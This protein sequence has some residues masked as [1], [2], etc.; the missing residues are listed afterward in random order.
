V[1]PEQYGLAV[2]TVQG[3]RFTHGDAAIPFCVQ[4]SSKPLTYCMATELHGEAT[5]HRHIGHEPNGRAFNATVLKKPEGIPHNPFINAG[6]IMAASLVKMEETEDARFDYVTS[7]WS[8]LTGGGKIGFQNSTYM[9]ERATASRNFC[10]GYMMA[11][12]GAFPAG[13]DLIKTLESYFM[14]CSLEITCE[15]MSVVAATLANGGICPLTEDRVFQKQTVT[16]CLSLMLSCGMYVPSLASPLAAP[17]PSRLTYKCFLVL[18][19]ITHH[20]LLYSFPLHVVVMSA[21]TRYDYSGE[22]GFLVGI[23]TKSGVSGVLCIVVPG[24]TGISTWSPRLDPLGNSVRGVDFCKAL[25]REFPFHPFSVPG[26]TARPLPTKAGHDERAAAATAA[27]AG[28]SSFEVAPLCE[29]DHQAL[30]WAAY[31]GDLQRVRQVAARGAALS[32]ADYDER[33]ALH[34]AASEGHVDVIRYLAAH[35]AMCG[36]KDRLGNTPLDDARRGGHVAAAAVLEAAESAAAARAAV[37]PPPPPTTPGEVLF[38]RALDPSNL[39]ST[40]RSCLR[41]SLQRMGVLRPNLGTTTPQNHWFDTAV[42]ALE[43]AAASNGDSNAAT[44]GDFEAVF[45]GRKAAL[46]TPQ[47]AACRFV[48]RALTGNLVVPNWPEFE[49]RLGAIAT[50]AGTADGTGGGVCTDVPLLGGAD[51][52][53]WSCSACSVDGQRASFGSSE[54]AAATAVFSAQSLVRPAMYAIAQDLMSLEQV[55]ARSSALSRLTSAF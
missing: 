20:S 9:G 51:P 38:S 15:Q 53:L 39:G 14:Y 33:T 48:G 34:L 23:P 35:G 42:G 5:V 55:R 7:V 6:A 2:C 43:E 30:W 45:P 46:S 8:R 3:Q 24:V 26:S 25:C 37:R 54:G 17:L 40:P 21:T 32:A 52:A 19:L 31:R 18:L 41:E 22:W 28:G 44:F 49:K 36:A 12:E 29:G 47:Q 16:H 10:L 50:A 1:N 4:S 11:E 27:A 13:T